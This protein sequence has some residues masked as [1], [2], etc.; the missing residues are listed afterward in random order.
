MY[1]LH[2]G[3]IV[4]SPVE[5]GV[6]TPWRPTLGHHLH[7]LLFLWTLIQ[8][9]LMIRLKLELAVWGKRRTSELWWVFGKRRLG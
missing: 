8:L 2:S 5:P 1:R 7:E 4:C 6:R 3:R 9:T